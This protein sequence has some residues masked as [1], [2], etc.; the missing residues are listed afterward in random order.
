[1]E[2]ITNMVSYVN[3]KSERKERVYRNVM[4]H[5][6]EYG[7]YMNILYIENYLES[8]HADKLF[9]Y[10][11]QIRYNSD[12][13]S[14][15]NIM[16]KM[17]KIPRKQIAYGESYT[18]YHFSGVNVNAYDWNKRNNDINS[19]AGREIKKVA[20]IVG[21]TACCDFNYVLV[22]RYLDQ[23]NSIGFHSD[24]ERELGKYPT[25]AGISLGQEREMQFMSKV[26]GRIIKMP[27]KHN[28]VYIMF[29]PTNKYWK[30][31]IPKKTRTLGERISLTFRKIQNTN[32]LGKN[33]KI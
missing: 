10:L 17:M 22:N 3:Q 21:D 12:E 29:Y 4:R 9:A 11:K 25:I 18:N 8:I 14:R 20:S 1:M 27:L 26:T 2:S 23:T 13:E 16:G 28:S 6:G 33:D 31:A 19:V 5:Y 30:H 24:D 15:V 7:S 32:K